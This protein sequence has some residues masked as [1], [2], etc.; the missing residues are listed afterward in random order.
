[1]TLT[2]NYAHTIVKQKKSKTDDY[3]RGFSVFVFLC[4]FIECK[5]SISSEQSSI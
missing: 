2:N 3:F 5:L 1:M 4:I